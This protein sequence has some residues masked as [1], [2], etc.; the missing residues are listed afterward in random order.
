MFF[1]RTG[2]LSVDEG[3]AWV[4][5]QFAP[6][7]GTDFTRMF[8]EVAHGDTAR[9]I[10]E[11]LGALLGDQVVIATPGTW[12]RK[13]RRQWHTFWNAADEPCEI[14]EII[15]PAGF[16]DFF[17]QLPSVWGGDLDRFFRIVDQ[18][19]WDN[20]S[21]LAALPIII[22]LINQR[23]FQTVHWGAMMFLFNA[24]RMSRGE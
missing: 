16:E 19:I 15:S 4:R 23:R 6:Y 11:E 2:P 8:W 14:I 12:V 3:R 5:G 22:H 10:G 13:P 1:E 17:R 24:R 7:R 20:H 21:R 9:E 18:A